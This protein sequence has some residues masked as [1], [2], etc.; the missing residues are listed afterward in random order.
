MSNSLL[1]LDKL[2]EA[3]KEALSLLISRSKASGGKRSE[4][5]SLHMEIRQ[6][7]EEKEQLSLELQLQTPSEHIDSNDEISDEKT[8][9]FSPREI[10]HCLRDIHSPT[11]LG[12]SSL[13]DIQLVKRELL[14]KKL[15][16]TPY[17]RGLVLIEVLNR[18]IENLKPRGDK[19]Y[20]ELEW[21]YYSSLQL[22]YIDGLGRTETAK[23]LGLSLPHYDRIHRGS[24]DV[25]IQVLRDFEKEALTKIQNTGS[26]KTNLLRRPI[27]FVGRQNE[28]ERIIEA[29]CVG[30]RQWLVIILGPGG[31]GKT[32]LANEVAHRLRE[33]NEFEAYIWADARTEVM[34]GGN[35][36]QKQQEIGSLDQLFH[37]VGE[38]IGINL[39]RQT[40][41]ERRNA[42]IEILHKNRCLLIIDNFEALEDQSDFCHFLD[43][44]VPEPSKVI[45]TT[46]HD[47]VEGGRIV[48]LNGLSLEE[49]KQL[50]FSI[51]GE[52]NIQLLMQPDEHLLDLIWRATDGSPL[53]LEWFVGQ[54]KI[55]G[56]TPNELAEEMLFNQTGRDEEL[57]EFCFGRSYSELSQNDRLI[58]SYM[59]F[60]IS[61]LGVS[62]PT[63]KSLTNLDSQ[64]FS[65]SISLLRR[66]SLITDIMP[67]RYSTNDLTTR[68]IVNKVEKIDLSL[69][70]DCVI[71]YWNEFLR[72]YKSDYGR[73]NREY[74]NILFIIDWCFSSE[75]IS[76]GLTLLLKLG[77]FL[78][79]H[80][81][82]SELLSYSKSF[83]DVAK[84]LG[85]EDSVA[86]LEIEHIG[87]INYHLKNWDECR[88]H[89]LA[90]LEIAERIDNKLLQALALRNLG[91]VERDDGQLQV[92]KNT[93]ERALSILDCLNDEILLSTIEGSYIV[94]LRR[95]GEYQKAEE[96]LLKE[97]RRATGIQDMERI[98]MATYRLGALAHE[99]HD[100][101]KAERLLLESINIDDS[102]ERFSSEAYTYERLSKVYEE[103]KSLQLAINSI[104][105]AIELFEQ[106]GAAKATIDQ[107]K[108]KLEALSKE[109]Y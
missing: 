72:L 18:A 62:V 95:L 104:T 74:R 24:I 75:K 97:I 32:T 7:E 79:K 94:T 70:L 64:K 33:S 96:L 90:G 27:N 22:R 73:V 12:K 86:R 100:L 99:T 85:D 98:A 14:G 82:W 88:N 106:I 109:I 59:P 30:H 40:E 20:S 71:N 57:L 80:G 81:H 38:G 47:T 28:V 58:L 9:P 83:L 29:L 34:R 69:R 26:T 52:Q 11:I 66:L 25:L 19:T 21:R 63:L 45:I 84:K 55:F 49:M 89:S 31:I 39:S 42:A 16:D 108:N 10:T 50:L 77:D 54:V 41:V 102:L 44:D 6:L 17:N 91:L 43:A 51:V 4:I 13:S 1:H 76:Q 92:S 48:K 67:G 101:S 87:W 8:D 2:I 60:F 103:M 3:K 93:F 5:D 107:L 15:E 61:S 46:R 36:R 53:A 23:E 56:I 105:R 35:R 68:F 37:L 65:N 78:F